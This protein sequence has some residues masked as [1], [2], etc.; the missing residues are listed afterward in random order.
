MH[1]TC[2]IIYSTIKFEYQKNEARTIFVNEKCECKTQFIHATKF[3]FFFYPTQD[4]V[5]L[6]IVQL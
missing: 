4:D 6:K 2:V 1:I 5:I 3:A